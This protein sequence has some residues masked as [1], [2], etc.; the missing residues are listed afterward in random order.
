MIAAAIISFIVWGHHMFVTGIGLTSTKLYTVTTI[1]VSLPFDV[2]VIAMIETLVKAR[3]RLKAAALF[4]LGAVALFVIGGITGVYL[5]SVALDHAL[6]G[7]YF[8]VAH[9]HYIMVGASIMGLIGGLYYWFPKM[10]GRMY[11]EGLAKIHFIFSWNGFEI[12]LTFGN[13]S[14][15]GRSFHRGLLR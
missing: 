12:R 8:V 9:F 1:A 5:A 13:R 14:H 3:V 11:N 15:H 4:T 10:T 6:R 2:M 7:T